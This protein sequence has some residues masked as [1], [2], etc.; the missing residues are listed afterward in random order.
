MQIVQLP[1]GTLVQLPDPPGI[2]PVQAIAAEAPGIAGFAAKGAKDIA[3]GYLGGMSALMPQGKSGN[4]PLDLMAAATKGSGA[5]VKAVLP[6]DPNATQNEQL[7][8]KVLEGVGG[9]GVMPTGTGIVPSALTGGMS[10]LG[11]ELG[12]RFGDRVLPGAGGTFGQ[13]A[14]SGLVG[15]LTGFLT[16]PKQSLGQADIRRALGAEP[17]QTFADAVG[18]LSDF[19]QTGAKTATLAEAFPQNS[20]IM[21]LADKARGSNLKNALRTQTEGRPQD[22]QSLGGFFLDRINP[23]VDANAVANKAGGSANAFLSTEKEARNAGIANRLAATPPILPQYIASVQNDLRS[24]ASAQNRP[25]AAAAYRKVADALSGQNG[26]L[27][28][29]QDLSLAI[30]ELRTAAKNPNAP[31]YQTGGVSKVDLEQAIEAAR[32]GI[33]Q[34]SPG[35]GQALDDFAKY[36]Q[37][38]MTPSRQGPI[39]SLSDRN[40]LLAGQTPVSRLGGLV[41]GNEPSTI[42]AVTRSLA[43]PVLTGGQPTN[44]LEIARALMQQK[45]GLGSTNPG[46]AVRGLPGSDVEQQIAALLQSGG[47]NPSEV[48]QPLSVADKLQPFA[49]SAG[50]NEP[51]RLGAASL[52]RPF[53]TIDMLASGHTQR[54]VQ[55]EIA[56]LLASPTPEALANLQRIAQFDPNVRKMLMAQGIV[57]PMLQN[58]GGR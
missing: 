29:P 23:P 8:S 13:M 17:P 31:I 43:D 21:A 20:G 56:R 18:N 15:G 14:G 10:S 37:N 19:S 32:Q 11:G 58:Q 25:G 2:G 51:P 45:L 4:I 55:D 38:V 57:V 50:I 22:L 28:S 48:M 26:V 33:S 1:D 3:R 40:P 54:G 41:T 27:T 7:F 6:E 53:R 35:F 52:I 49:Q 16:G 30:V 34:S 42:N 39:G 5:A 9:A 12:K 46:S 24:I 44:P 36:S 47:K